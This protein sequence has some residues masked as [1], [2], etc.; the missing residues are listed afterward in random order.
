MAFFCLSNIENIPPPPE[1]WVLGG[2]GEWGGSI[3]G[4][5]RTFLAPF[6]NRSSDKKV[7][8]IKKF[9]KGHISIRRTKS[10]DVAF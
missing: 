1:I 3:F 5:F 4:A 6:F 10:F 8:K 7:Q 9:G 2:Q